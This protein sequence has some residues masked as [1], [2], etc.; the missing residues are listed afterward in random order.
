MRGSRGN[1][2]ICFVYSSSFFCWATSEFG[3]QIAL[4][5]ASSEMTTA[6][7]ERVRRDILPP[8]LSIWMWGSRGGPAYRTNVRQPGSAGNH[9]RGGDSRPVRG[10]G[11]DRAHDRQLE[12]AL[13]RD[14]AHADGRGVGQ[15]DAEMVRRTEP[16]VK[17]A[18]ELH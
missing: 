13:H 3:E 9:L 10:P 16:P 17:D 8:C 7:I 2:L 6:C 1:C 18:G 11:G 14:V 15:P 12:R 5:A 4:A